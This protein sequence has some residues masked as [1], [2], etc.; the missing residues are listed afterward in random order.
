M[1]EAPAFP[2]P[3]DDAGLHAAWQH[4]WSDLGVPAPAGLQA[5]LEQAY[6]QPHRHYHARRHLSECLA[7][8]ER[9][10]D[11]AE[12]PGEVALALWW[13]DAVYEPRESDNEQRSADWASRCLL[14]AGAAADAAQRVH[15]LIMTTRHDAPVQDADAALL[16]DIDLA[17]LGSPPQRFARYDEDIRKEYGWVPEDV[18]RH[19]RAEVLKQF[20]VR[21]PLYQTARAQAAFEG[22]AKINLRAALARLKR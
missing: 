17:I 18:Y 11:Q 10:R 20:L 19:K 14:A 12:R 5:Q 22:Q 9:W 7:L 16:V 1:P 15:T 8:F 4:A 3:L 21:E 2:Q 13:H 6:A